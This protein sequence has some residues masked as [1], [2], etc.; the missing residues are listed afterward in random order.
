[1]STAVVATGIANPDKKIEEYYITYYGLIGLSPSHT[2]WFT[3]STAVETAGIP[4]YYKNIE[5]LYS[6]YLYHGLIFTLGPG[7][8]LLG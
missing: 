8:P 2:V 4:N 5:E 1:M 6:I 3:V 7:W